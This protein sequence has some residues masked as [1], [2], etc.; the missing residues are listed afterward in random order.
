MNSRRITALLLGAAAL[1]AGA[2][3]AMAG[4]LLQQGLPGQSRTPDDSASE[5]KSSFTAVGPVR[6]ESVAQR[7]RPDYD[8]VPVNVGAFQLFPAL[9]IGEYYD[10]NIYSTESDHED[11][12]ITVLV[13]TATLI[14]NWGRHEVRVSGA[15]AAYRYGEHKDEDNLNGEIEAEGR[16]DISYET[17]LKANAGYSAETERRGS[18]SAPTSAAEPVRYYV[19]KGGLH[20]YRGAGK[21]TASAGYDA[22]NYKFEDPDQISGGKI[23]QSDRDR[24]DHTITTE[25]TYKLHTEN[26][27]PFLK[28][29]YNIRDYKTNPVRDSH[30]YEI[31]AGTRNDFGVMETEFYAGLMTQEYPDLVDDHISALDYGGKLLWNMTGMTSLEATMRRYMGETTLGGLTNPNGSN[32]Y[33]ATEADVTLMHELRR[34]LILASHLK[35]SWRTYKGGGTDQEE[36]VTEF[37]GG[38]RYLLNRN[39]YGDM[40]YNYM[41]QDA[42]VPSGDY[43]KHSVL[44]RVG[45]QY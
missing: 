38:A 22:V 17:W 3:G 10:S 31:V 37:G 26:F 36:T 15:G 33:L 5:I 12:L 44:L 41:S 43:D 45:L 11:D 29:T 42:N 20:A 14:S 7:V 28:G 34:Y 25:L 16:Y 35:E 21:L 6:G 9:E 2:H 13:P 19:A 30:G 8:P 40:T 39:V 18:P 1:L 23:D 32:A 27:R 4:G 24:T